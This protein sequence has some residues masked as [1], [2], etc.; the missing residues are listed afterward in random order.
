MNWEVVDKPNTEE[1]I[2][3]RSSKGELDRVEVSLDRQALDKGNVNHCVSNVKEVQNIKDVLK[4]DED[5]HKI[6]KIYE[7]NLKENNLEL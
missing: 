3:S 2:E 4:I 7:T 6:E 5:T 1:R